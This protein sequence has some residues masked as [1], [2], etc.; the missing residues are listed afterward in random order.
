MAA[1]MSNGSQAHPWNGGMSISSRTVFC[2]PVASVKK[3]GMRMT[4]AM[5]RPHY[6]H[7][8]V[9]SDGSSTNMRSKAETRLP[10]P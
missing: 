10:I 6:A 1:M 5:R 7:F 4:E 9:V 3:I 2:Q 8:L